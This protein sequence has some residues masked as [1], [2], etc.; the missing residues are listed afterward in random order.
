ME[1]HMKRLFVLCLLSWCAMA[2]RNVPITYR[3][4]QAS[5]Q[6]AARTIAAQ[7]GLG[8]NWQQS[9]DQTDPQC[10]LWVRDLR[11]EAV[12][13]E[14]AMQQILDPVGLGYKIENGMVVLYRAP[15][16]NYSTGRKS[17]H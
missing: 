9:F 5:V 8:Y 4:T 3:P 17:A 2:Q 15:L 1:V 13:F 16:I 6:D 14:K 10:R 11:I 12:P 7:A